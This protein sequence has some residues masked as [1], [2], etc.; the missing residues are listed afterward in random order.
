MV[1]LISAGKIQLFFFFLQT[2][3]YYEAL[4]VNQNINHHIMAYKT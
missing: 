4:H 2:H 1:L 3:S